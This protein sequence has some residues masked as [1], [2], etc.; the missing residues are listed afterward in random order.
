MNMKSWSFDQLLTE[1]IRI[2]FFKAYFYFYIYKNF[3]GALV[4]RNTL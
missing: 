2:Y 1:L 3:R 4:L